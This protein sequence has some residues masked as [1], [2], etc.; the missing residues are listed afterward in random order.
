MNYCENN[1]HSTTLLPDCLLMHGLYFMDLAGEFKNYNTFTTHRTRWRED[2]THCFK[3]FQGISPNKI[4]PK[5]KSNYL[6]E[7]RPATKNGLPS[8]PASFSLVSFSA[9]RRQAAV[10]H[11]TPAFVVAS[12]I[13]QIPLHSTGKSSCAVCEFIEP[14]SAAVFVSA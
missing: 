3:T 13:R 11:S 8:S 9:T 10:Y 7:S 6:A 14:E 5:L 12:E 2:A 1:P 4:S